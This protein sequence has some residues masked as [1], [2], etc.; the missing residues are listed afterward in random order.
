[1][2]TQYY[3]P[4]ADKPACSTSHR[5]AAI[6]GDELN[7]ELER[8]ATAQGTRIANVYSNFIGHG[9]G[10]GGGNEYV[11]GDKCGD[12]EGA[13][14]GLAGFLPGIGGHFDARL[15]KDYDPHPNSNGVSA[16]ADAVMSA[17]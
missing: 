4:I 17:L 12:A 2:V 6:I 9:A 15:K 16:I 8:R 1:M 7:D 14:T 10:A 13:A 11:F 5:I 3:N